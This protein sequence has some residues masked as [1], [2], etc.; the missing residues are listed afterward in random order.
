VHAAG[1]EIGGQRTEQQ[2]RQRRSGVGRAQRWKPAGEVER[3]ERRGR[4]DREAV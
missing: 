4:G 2:A 1:D 3:R